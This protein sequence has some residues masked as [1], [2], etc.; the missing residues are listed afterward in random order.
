MLARTEGLDIYFSSV[1]T[2]V[3]GSGLLAAV[4][5]TKN[6]NKLHAARLLRKRVFL[7]TPV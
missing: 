1:P 5:I 3:F 4:K 7:K 6:R 2:L